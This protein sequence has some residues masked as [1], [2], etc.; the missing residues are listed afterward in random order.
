MENSDLEATLLKIANVE[1][2][3]ANLLKQ[4]EDA[5][6]KL[7]SLREKLAISEHQNN[8]RPSLST[9][10]PDHIARPLTSGDKVDLF[11][12]RFQG[13]DD[14]YPKLWQNS[15]TGKKGYSPACD[16]EWVR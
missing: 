15:K 7:K 13:R 12:R 16:N 4:K 14:V 8:I 9:S 11:R 6:A 3:L 10:P 2:H 1:K 5:E